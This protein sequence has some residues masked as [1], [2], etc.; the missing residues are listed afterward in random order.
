MANNNS[1]TQFSFHQQRSSQNNPGSSHPPQDQSQQQH[2]QHHRTCG[3]RPPNV[4]VTMHQN[5]FNNL[6]QAPNYHIPVW[7]NPYPQQVCN[8]YRVVE[9]STTH[10]GKMRFC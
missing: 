8:M 4:I 5:D 2:Q 7:N 3:H 10:I 1:R 6:N 9:R